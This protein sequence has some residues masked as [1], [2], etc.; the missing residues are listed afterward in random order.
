MLDKVVITGMGTVNP[1]GLS[2]QETWENAINGVSGIGPITLFDSKGYRVQHACE[3]N[4]AAK[5]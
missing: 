4:C 5:D 1:L 2:V 3:V